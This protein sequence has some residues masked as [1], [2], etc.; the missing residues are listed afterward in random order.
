MLPLAA[1][2]PMSNQAITI[3][4]TGER[5]H[6]FDLDALKEEGL[7]KIQELAGSEWTDFNFHD[8]GVTILEVLCYALT[9]LA[10]RADFDIADI[11]SVPGKKKIADPLFAPEEI[12]TTAPLSNLDFRRLILDME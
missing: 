11:L 6:S 3:K 12:L 7:R 8:P 10:Y 1:I 9:D 2:S 5:D 4:E